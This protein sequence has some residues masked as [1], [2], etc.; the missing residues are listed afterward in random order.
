MRLQLGD[1]S[2]FEVSFQ[3]K[4]YPSK[5][6]DTAARQVFRYQ[7]RDGKNIVR[8]FRNLRHGGAVLPSTG[9]WPW[10]LPHPVGGPR[11]KGGYPK[12]VELLGQV[13]VF[14]KAE[15]GFDFPDVSVAKVIELTPDL[16][17]GLPHNTKQKDPT[18]R[19][20]TS[21]YELIPMDRS[22]F[23]MMLDAGMTCLHVSKEQ[24]AWVE[25]TS[26]FYWGPSV[27]DLPMPVSL[28]QSAYL[29]PALYYDEPAVDARDQVLRPRLEKDSEF[30]K[31]ITPQVARDAFVEVFRHAWEEGAPWRLIRQLKT[32]ED[33]SVGSMFFPQANLYTWETM[34]STG[35]HQ[36]SQ[37][38]QTPAAIVFEPPGR[39][40]T[41]RC[42]PEIN[43]TYECQ[44]PPEDPKAFTSL[45]YGLLRGAARQSG[46]SWGMSIL[47]PSFGR[48]LFNIRKWNHT[49]S[50]WWRVGSIFGY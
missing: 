45:L 33:Y 25:D 14:D 11:S 8:E 43:M 12:R 39:I 16:L 23:D 7:V 15:V 24:I 10:L 26:V 19:F 29:G 47:G 17:L 37:H 49:P 30:R 9:A 38:P 41:R 36:L 32:R 34:V 40:G 22:D 3:S 28:Y 48:S 27:T 44:F 21:D 5:D 2:F 50:L 46:K 4:G 20:D 31:Q 42:L 18:R 1:D 13:Y 35:Y 6:L